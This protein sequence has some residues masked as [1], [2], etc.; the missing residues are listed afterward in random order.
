MM[1]GFSAPCPILPDARG[2]GRGFTLILPLREDQSDGY[3]FCYAE[4]DSAVRG[5]AHDGHRLR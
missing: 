5:G 2:P 4:S 1:P 3:E